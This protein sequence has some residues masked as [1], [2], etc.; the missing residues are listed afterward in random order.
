[1]RV[2]TEPGRKKHQGEGATYALAG[3]LLPFKFLPRRPNIRTFCTISEG[4]SKAIIYAIGYKPAESG[5][6]YWGKNVRDTPTW[7]G[8]IKIF[9]LNRIDR[10]VSCSVTLA[11]SERVNLY[12][13]Q[14]MVLHRKT[15]KFATYWL[16][17][18]P[19]GTPP[20]LIC[21]GYLH[22]PPTALVGSMKWLS[23]ETVARDGLKNFNMCK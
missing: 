21:T 10:I 7:A 5:P 11:L 4:L 9:T 22:P 8:Q 18:P 1:L 12:N 3:R 23:V 19:S 15:R 14:I 6:R 16:H 13:R 2:R 17:G 20:P